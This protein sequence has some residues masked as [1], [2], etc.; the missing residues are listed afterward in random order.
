MAISL[1]PSHQVIANCYPES[2]KLQAV[3]RQEMTYILNCTGGRPSDA[4]R[5][6]CRYVQ[7]A[8]NSRDASKLAS[9]TAQQMMQDFLDLD[10]FDTR[11]H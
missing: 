11:Y 4:A 9:P 10:G 3:A 6:A 5:S 1:S 2:G 8:Q 7:L